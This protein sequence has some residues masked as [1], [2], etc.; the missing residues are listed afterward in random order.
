MEFQ[1]SVSDFV[2]TTSGRTARSSMVLIMHDNMVISIASAS[3]IV[4]RRYLKKHWKTPR[5]AEAYYFNDSLPALAASKSKDFS[6]LPE[7]GSVEHSSSL[8]ETTPKEYTRLDILFNFA[9]PV[10]W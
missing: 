6:S 3:R 9:E 5:D 7:E 2:Y 10:F 1:K 4:T 8:T